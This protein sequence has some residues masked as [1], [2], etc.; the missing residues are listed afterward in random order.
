MIVLS[1]NKK[2][3][4]LGVENVNSYDYNEI[5]TRE[6]NFAIN[7]LLGVEMLWNIQSRENT[8]FFVI[9]TNSFVFSSTSVYWA[10]KNQ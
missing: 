5:F 2:M 6:S 9:I 3:I 7:D 8:I 1:T 10:G 4:A